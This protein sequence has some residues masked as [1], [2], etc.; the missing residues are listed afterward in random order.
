MK[1][2]RRFGKP[3][4]T[5]YYT[6]QVFHVGLVD[7][8]LANAGYL[9]MAIGEK[10]MACGPVALSRL[11]T[12]TTLE[13]SQYVRKVA[14]KRRTTAQAPVSTKASFLVQLDRRF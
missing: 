10:H 7:L 13:M 9:P 5:D 6:V 8:A 14:G 12:R 4:S 1:S 2:D 11:E 3:T